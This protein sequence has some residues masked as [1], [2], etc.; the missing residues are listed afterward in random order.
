MVTVF[1]GAIHNT[2]LLHL[3]QHCPSRLPHWTGAEGQSPGLPEDKPRSL[4]KGDRE[5]KEGTGSPLV[6]LGL[7]KGSVL[8]VMRS[9]FGNKTINGN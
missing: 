7:K 6:L 3:G 2:P 8:Q 4:K 5:Y 9:L 1:P